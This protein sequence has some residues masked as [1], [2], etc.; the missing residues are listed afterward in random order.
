M[1]AHLYGLYGWFAKYRSLW[2][3]LPS[4]LVL[5]WLR[6]VPT[7][8]SSVILMSRKLWDSMVCLKWSFWIKTQDLFPLFGRII[9]IYQWKTI[10]QHRLSS[11]DWLANWEGESGDQRY[12]EDMLYGSKSELDWCVAINEVYV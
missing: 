10:I 12:V 6:I 4:W 8:I 1:G 9:E 2:V 3:V 5:S 7:L 11:L